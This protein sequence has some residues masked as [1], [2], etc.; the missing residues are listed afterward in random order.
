MNCTMKE[1]VPKYNKIIPNLIIPIDT[2]FRHFSGEDYEKDAELDRKLSS[3]LHHCKETARRLCYEDYSLTIVSINRMSSSNLTLN[4]LSPSSPYLTVEF[5]PK[6][7]LLDMIVY[8]MSALGTWFGFVIVNVNPILIFDSV[9]KLWKISFEKS[10]PPNF[11]RQTLS[12]FRHPN[13]RSYSMRRQ[14]E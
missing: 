14:K 8:A 4:V 5:S 2:N 3:I 11:R 6:M 13:L 1:T 7:V 10:D 9:K 12:Q